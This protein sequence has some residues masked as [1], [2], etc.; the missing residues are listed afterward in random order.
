MNRRFFLS[1]TFGLAAL[2][3]AAA[4]ANVDPAALPQS[5]EATAG[6][7]GLRPNSSADQGPILQKLLDEAAAQDRPVVLPPGRFIVSNV[8]LPAKTR[9]VGTAGATR[10]VLGDGGSLFTGES[11]EIVSLSGLV[12]DGTGGRLDAYVPALIHLAECPNVGIENCEFL[13]SPASGIALDRSGGRIAHSRVTKAAAAGIRTI[14]STGLSIADNLIEDCGNGGILVWRWS[15]GEDGTI[16][17]GNRV[18]RIAAND[19]G[20]GENGNGINVFRAH[21]CLVSNNHISDCAFTAVRANSANNVQILGNNCRGLG[22]VAIF[23]EFSFAGSVIANNIVDRAGSGISVSNF[24]EGG[25]IAVV[26]NNVVRDITGTG[27]LPGDTERLGVGIAVEADV[28]LNGNIVDGAPRFGMV[29]GWG[30]YLRDVAATG[31]VVRRAPVGIAVSVVEGAGAAVISDN[32]ISGAT[33]AAVRGMRWSEPAT[34]DLTITGAADFPHLSVE[35]NR[36]S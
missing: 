32:L 4:A 36:V 30:P 35:R 11:A 26:A 23:C 17:S 10:L 33:S 27:P 12:L 7:E 18:A 2:T 16:V 19:G 9:I 3:P 28:T 8:R 34:D 13:G 20:T 14:E 31:N 29:L 25:R 6:N 21:G 24:R 5:G 1:G 22:E 15:E